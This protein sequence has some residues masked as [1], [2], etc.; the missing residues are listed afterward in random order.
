MVLIEIFIYLNHSGTYIY[1]YLFKSQWYLY[2]Y[3]YPFKSHWYLYIYIYIFIYLVVLICT[4][5]FN[6]KQAETLHFAHLFYMFLYDS[7]PLNV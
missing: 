3:L 7:R 6:V 4:I 1:L 2:M 5:C